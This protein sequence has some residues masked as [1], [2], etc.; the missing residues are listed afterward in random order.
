MGK[1]IGQVTINQLNRIK[2]IMQN[3]LLKTECFTEEQ[4]FEMC[5]TLNHFAKTIEKDSFAIE[6][7]QE[8]KDTFLETMKKDCHKY[9]AIDQFC[10]DVEDAYQE[11]LK[12][13]EAMA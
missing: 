11:E 9:R 5:H 2:H 7:V 1:G 6:Y 10:H 3:D 13:I 12:F 4:T 8:Q